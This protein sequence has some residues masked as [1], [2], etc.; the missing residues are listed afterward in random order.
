MMPPS[1]S[2]GG[3]SLMSIQLGRMAVPF[4]ERNDI[5]SFS[6]CNPMQGIEITPWDSGWVLTL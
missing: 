4:D 6:R 2:I 1:W 3:H 5:T